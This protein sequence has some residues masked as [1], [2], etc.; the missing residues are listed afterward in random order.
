MKL[1]AWLKGRAVTE[2][3][4]YCYGPLSQ[5]PARH[6]SPLSQRKRSLDMPGV[7]SSRGCDACRKVKK[8]V[9]IPKTTWA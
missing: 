6:P 3:T 2:M 8:K 1:V 9:W 5:S 4:S 7:P